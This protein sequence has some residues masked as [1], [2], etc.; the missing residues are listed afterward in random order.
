MALLAKSHHKLSSTMGTGIAFVQV[1]EWGSPVL[2]IPRAG[3]K[4]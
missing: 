2:T 3:H 4:H 1:H